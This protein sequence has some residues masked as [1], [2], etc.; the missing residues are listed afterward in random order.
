M[1]NQAVQRVLETNPYPVTRHLE[2]DGA[3]HVY[4]VE[5]RVEPPPY[6]GTIV[7]DCFHNLR[8]ALDSI[9]YD[10]SGDV[11]A[12]TDQELKGI[13]FPIALCPE[14]YNGKGTE[15]IPP[16]AQAEVERSQPYH[17]PVPE[18]ES[19]WR[20]NEFNRLDKHRAVQVVPAI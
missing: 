15:L 18:I 8:S 19:L 1:L 3:E 6:L 7:G 11:S 2:R 13:G 16:C 4:R 17:G 20:I 9:V 14:S 5:K 12:L 10:L